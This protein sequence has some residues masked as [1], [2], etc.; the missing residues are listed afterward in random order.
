MQCNTALI[1]LAIAFLTDLQFVQFKTH[2]IVVHALQIYFVLHGR[3]YIHCVALPVGWGDLLHA[4][5][6]QPVL[7]L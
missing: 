6:Q 1:Y 4:L 7:P 2:E 5:T 3:H